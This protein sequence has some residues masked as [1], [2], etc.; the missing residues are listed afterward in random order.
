MATNSDPCPLFFGPVKSAIRK[1][2][3]DS[4][5]DAIDVQLNAVERAGLKRAT[6]TNSREIPPVTN[7]TGERTA[8]VERKFVGDNGNA[9]NRYR[10]ATMIVHFDVR[11]TTPSITEATMLLIGLHRHLPRAIGDGML[12]PGF[13]VQ[14]SA[15]GID[16]NPVELSIITP[17][18]PDDTV[19]TAKSYE[20]FCI[21]RA[22]GGIFLDSP[23]HVSATLRVASPPTLET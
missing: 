13:A 20:S 5:M 4:G 11:I 9:R 8:A 15:V 16:G 17:R 10:V 6:I 12:F 23:E 14:P 21:V 7:R 22:E 18:F 2:L 3:V 1:A 19:A